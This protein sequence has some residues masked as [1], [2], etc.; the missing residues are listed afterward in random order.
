MLRRP[1]GC[2][3]AQLGL[4]LILEQL[5]YG[6]ETIAVAVMPLHD[7]NVLLPADPTRRAIARG[8]YEGD[9]GDGSDGG[10]GGG[11]LAEGGTAVHL[12]AHGGAGAL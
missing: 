10:T 8:L 11:D 6:L 4:A 9:G 7:P 1:S 3:K 12:H 2:E 5:Q